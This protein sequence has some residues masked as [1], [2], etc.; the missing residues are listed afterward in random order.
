ML[1]LFFRYTALIN[2]FEADLARSNSEEV[3]RFWRGIHK[4]AFKGYVTDDFI[5]DIDVQLKG[6][7][8][9]VYTDS[10]VYKVEEKN[11][12]T[13]HQNLPF[14][15]YSGINALGWAEKPQESDVFAY[16]FMKQG[17]TF[18]FPTES[19]LSFYHS[20]K[21]RVPPRRV[22]EEYGRVRPIPISLVVAKVTHRE[23]NHSSI[24]E[25]IQ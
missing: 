3:Q 9:L 19:L 16:A 1:T 10:G 11:D 18:Y 4:K 15:E 21:H 14:E 8:R 25:S 23:Y 20:V 2:T 7:D 22:K 17:V 5:T 24:L 12:Y 13:T 6:V